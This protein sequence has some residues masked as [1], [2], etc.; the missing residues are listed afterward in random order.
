M[1]IALRVGVENH[2]AFPLWKV[3]CLLCLVNAFALTVEGAIEAGRTL[4]TFFLI[5]HEEIRMKFKIFI[6]ENPA[7]TCTCTFLFCWQKE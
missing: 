7:R 6:A 4:K 5:P 3:M 2:L 1:P